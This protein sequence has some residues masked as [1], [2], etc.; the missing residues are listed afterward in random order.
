LKRRLPALFL[1]LV[2]IF[3]ISFGWAGM[4]GACHH[5][6]P[7]QAASLNE[8]SAPPCHGHEAPPCHGQE[9]RS[10]CH[11][12]D[13]GPNGE[14]CDGG[15]CHVAMA[16]VTLELPGFPSVHESAVAS[17]PPADLSYIPTPAH[18]PPIA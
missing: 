10:P 7:I 4:P 15:C 12:Q 9:P 6:A 13:G 1:L 11:G 3:R 17:P 14:G 18:R 5:S 2:L 8:A 16:M